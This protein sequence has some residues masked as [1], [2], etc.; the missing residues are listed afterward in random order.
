[1]VVGVDA[2]PSHGEILS[3]LQGRINLLG[4]TLDGA[5]LLKQHWPDGVATPKNGTAPSDVDAVAELLD[6]IEAQ[7]GAPFGEPDPRAP[8]PVTDRWQVNQ[9]TKQEGEHSN[10]NV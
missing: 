8:S 3:W 1:M 5:R 9:E 10:G 2:E 4:L 6:R 7:I